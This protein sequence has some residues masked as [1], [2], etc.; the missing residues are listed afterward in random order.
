M[1][2]KHSRALSLG[3]VRQEDQPYHLLPGIPTWVCS[4]PTEGQASRRPS[5]LLPPP[6]W[7]L[8]S[9]QQYPH[10]RYQQQRKQ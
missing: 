1:P 5:T 4:L 9:P 6:R 10:D 3:P 7:K 2:S 8:Y